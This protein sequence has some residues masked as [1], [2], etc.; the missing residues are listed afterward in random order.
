VLVAFQRY[1]LQL[2]V[3]SSASAAVMLLSAL[4]GRTP[5]QESTVAFV[6]A[7]SPVG[8]LGCHHRAAAPRVR[9]RGGI[10]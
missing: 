2:I 9:A 10:R 4:F 7:V 1:E 6:R 3:I 8:F 5:S